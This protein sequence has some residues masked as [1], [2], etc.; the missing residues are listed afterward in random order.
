MPKKNAKKVVPKQNHKAQLPQQQRGQ[1]RTRE[2]FEH[3]SSDEENPDYIPPETVE[4]SSDDDDDN[5]E[6]LPTANKVLPKKAPVPKCKPKQKAKKSKKSANLK[7][8]LDFYRENIDEG[9]LEIE[10]PGD[11]NCAYHS[12]ST[13]LFGSTQFSNNLR[14]AVVAY[15]NSIR[16]QIADI[17]GLDEV[18]IAQYLLDQAQPGVFANG[19]QLQYLAQIFQIVLRVF[20]ENDELLWEEFPNDLGDDNPF[21]LITVNLVYHAE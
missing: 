19:T 10:V 3:H 5:Y 4:S 1:K 11:G 16:D 8:G 14:A 20:D 7:Q 21:E 6:K 2:E 13:I 17:L 9:Q 12:V 15:Q 18:G